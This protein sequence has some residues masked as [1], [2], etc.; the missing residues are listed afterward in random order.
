MK[1]DDSIIFFLFALGVVLALGIGIMAGHKITAAYKDPDIDR[2]TIELDAA[3][4]H[5]GKANDG[6]DFFKQ[7]LKMLVEGGQLDG[8]DLK[9]RPSTQD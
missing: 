2:L 8:V 7:T 4:K 6:E 3:K 1:R 5:A 9:G